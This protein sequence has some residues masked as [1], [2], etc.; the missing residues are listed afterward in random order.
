MNVINLKINSKD[1]RCQ[2]GILALRKYCDHNDIPL[3]QLGVSIQKAGVFAVTDMV[4]FGHQA[5]CDLNGTELLGNRDE[6]TSSIEYFDDK[7]IG[8]IMESIMGI[9][10]L[11]K[12]IKDNEEQPKKKAQ[13]TSQ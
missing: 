10:I 6:C 8:L 5:Y 4:F 3:E 7:V 11:G 12:A 2:M 13:K 1:I 9:K